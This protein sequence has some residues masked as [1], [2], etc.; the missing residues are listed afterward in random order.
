MIDQMS[1]EREEKTKVVYFNTNSPSKSVGFFSLLPSRLA[2]NH[3]ET[4]A[5][6]SILSPIVSTSNNH[7]RLIFT[8]WKKCVRI[9]SSTVYTSSRFAFD[10][11]RKKRV[12]MH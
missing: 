10:E 11:Q 12:E 5:V 1:R 6:F 9:R 7:P 3:Q 2:D 8:I 4:A